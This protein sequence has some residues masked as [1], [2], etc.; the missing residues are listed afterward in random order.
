VGMLKAILLILSCFMLCGWGYRGFKYGPDEAMRDC[1]INKAERAKFLNWAFGENFKKIK[2]KEADDVWNRRHGNLFKMRQG[3]DSYDIV[4]K[5]A[6]VYKREKR[7][8][9]VK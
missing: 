5:A 6:R 7:A 3:L 4:Y 1:G 8:G 9:R 2:T